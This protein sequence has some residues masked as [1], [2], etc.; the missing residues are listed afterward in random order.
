MTFTGDRYE[1]E[2]SHRRNSGPKLDD[3]DEWDKNNRSRSVAQEA[4]GKVKELWNKTKGF[5]EAPDYR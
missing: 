1:E 2:P 5:D 4:I 3:I